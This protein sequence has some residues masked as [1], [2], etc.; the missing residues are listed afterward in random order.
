[1][2]FKLALIVVLLTG[3]VLLKTERTDADLIAERRQANNTFSA[4][5]LSFS[6]RNTANFDAVTWFFTVDHLKP[7]GY[8]VRA[9]K[10]RQDGKMDFD[11]TIKA[12]KKSGDDLLCNSLELTVM[13]DWQELY[14]GNLLSAQVKRAV[15]KDGSDDLVFV[16]KLNKKDLS[17]RQK[18]CDFS[19]EMRTYKQDP[20]EPE[21]G[22]WAKQELQNSIRTGTW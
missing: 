3:F 20:N 16:I 10:V 21:K 9:L 12:V 18:Q 5:T 4:T 2:R 6:N 13:K 17:L 7:E 1:M 11:Y 22:L 15:A 19:L 8:D 14:R